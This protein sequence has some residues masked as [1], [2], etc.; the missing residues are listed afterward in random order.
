MPEWIS[1]TYRG[2]INE[3]LFVEG[4]TVWSKTVGAYRIHRYDHGQWR[5]GVR[6]P[7]R[8]G[9][10]RQLGEQGGVRG[11]LPRSSGTLFQKRREGVHNQE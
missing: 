10:Q 1:I 7:G 11:T 4:A 5:I 2:G 6:D 9:C 8:G 3:L